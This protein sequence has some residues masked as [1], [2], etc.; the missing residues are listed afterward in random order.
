MTQVTYTVDYLKEKRA[1]LTL[2][3][4]LSYLNA[5]H[6]G[7]DFRRL[8]NTILR[9]HDKVEYEAKSDGGEGT[10]RFRPLHN[11]Q[12]EGTLLAYLQS[13]RT[14]QGL[15]VRE[16][17]DGWPEA[18]KAIKQLESEGKLLVTR[19][20]KDNHPRMIWVNDP[21]LSHTIDGEFQNIWKNIT[22]PEPKSLAD[23][24]ERVGLTPAN[25]SRNLKKPVKQE[26]KKP[27]KPR[28]G[29]KT[30]N[31]HMAGILRDYSHLKKRD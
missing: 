26:T 7:K 22:L 19:N 23:D 8:L 15:S 3:D 10:F 24:L 13:R 16:L 4:I 9:G 14:A 1:A 28:R 31:T 6:E 30:T 29:G 20:K 17:R 5:D 27:K 21:S 2:T 12:S 11:I 18:E 25:K